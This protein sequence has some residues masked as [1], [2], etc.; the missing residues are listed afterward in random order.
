M[1]AKKYLE[2]LILLMPL[3]LQALDLLKRKDP[4]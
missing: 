1:N 2:R 4:S 3:I